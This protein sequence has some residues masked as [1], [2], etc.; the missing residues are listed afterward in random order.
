M[1]GRT[2]IAVASALYCS[3]TM[4]NTLDDLPAWG[5]GL[6]VTIITSLLPDIDEPRSRIG[7][8]VTPLIPTWLRPVAFFIFGIAFIYLGMKMGYWWLSIFGA[9]LLFF[10]FVKHRES[11]THG[12]IGL[13]VVAAVSYLYNQDLII[14]VVLGYGSHLF[15]DVI[16]EGITLFWPV[17]KR[18][19]IPLM[20]TNSILER[21]IVYRAAQI[22]TAILSIQS[23]DKVVLQPV[24]GSILR[25]INQI[26]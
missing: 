26:W 8:M 14:P 4:P 15:L 11:P 18:I 23:L 24:Y 13:V 5:I 12:I 1:M 22:W 17:P 9:L 20:A 19:R 25:L 10:L 3:Y 16:T 7:G 21:W 2:H 6:G